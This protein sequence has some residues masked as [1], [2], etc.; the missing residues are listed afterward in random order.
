MERKNKFIIFIIISACIIA[1]EFYIFKPNINSCV[2]NYKNHN[3]WKIIDSSEVH[4]G[5]L[6]H[7]DEIFSFNLS[8]IS[9]ILSLLVS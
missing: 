4:D 7:Y 6:I 2:N 8:L 9:I 5:N 3:D 1:I